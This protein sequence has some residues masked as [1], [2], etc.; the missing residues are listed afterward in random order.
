MNKRSRDE[1]HLYVAALMVEKLKSEQRL[2]DEQAEQLQD[3][4]MRPRKHKH[5]KIVPKSDGIDQSTTSPP[6]SPSTGLIGSTPEPKKERQ[7]W[8]RKRKG[9]EVADALTSFPVGANPNTMED[10]K[11]GPTTVALANTSKFVTACYGTLTSIEIN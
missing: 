3:I 2:N 6:G 11:V 8:P 7:F 4:L 1:K 5:R 10:Y 9:K